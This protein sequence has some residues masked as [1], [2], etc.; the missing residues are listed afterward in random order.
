[1]NNVIYLGLGSNIGNRI[2]NIIF[3]LSALQSSGFIGIKKISSFYETSPIGPNQRKFYNIAVKAKTSLNPRDLLFIIKQIEELM[4]RKKT[5]HWGPR[6][7]DVDILFFNRIVIAEKN[8]IVPHK[9]IQNRLFVLIP[10]NEISKNFI[11]PNSNKKINVILS[12]KLLT[13]RCQKIK[14]LYK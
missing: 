1:M 9:E 5:L 13:L 8:L 2:E 12:E 7:I 10:L 6:I 4:G 14:M 3:A 11:C